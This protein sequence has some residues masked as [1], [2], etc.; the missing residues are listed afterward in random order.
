M[1]RRTRVAA[2]LAAP[3]LLL[4]SCT[5]AGGGTTTAPE[6]QGDSRV[7]V[8]SAA[9]RSQKKAAGIEDCR[10]GTGSTVDG[11]LPAVTLPCLGGGPDVRLSSLRG[12]L[13]VNLFA[14]WCGP[15]REELPYYQEL[16]AK[17]G[18]KLDVLGVDY[19]DTQPSMA[20]DLVKS[21]GVTYPLLADP[22]A[23]LRKPLHVRGLPGIVLVDA[24]GKVTYLNYQSFHSYPELRDL[25]AS[26]LGVDLAG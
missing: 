12:P 24:H 17:A 4:A 19:L 25:V 8:D 1:T 3:L 10:P 14:Q 23:S 5:S 9:L 18:D 6:P 20:L 13:V 7:S 2:L 11:G 16:A 15:C 26:K 22:S 21:S